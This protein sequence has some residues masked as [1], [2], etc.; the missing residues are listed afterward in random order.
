MFL[1]YEDAMMPLIPE[2]KF[3][4]MIQELKEDVMKR[5]KSDYVG[6][7]VNIFQGLYTYQQVGINISPYR[8]VEEAA[9]GE[10]M[11]Y[12]ELM[13][14]SHELA[15]QLVR[16][17][18]DPFK[19]PETELNASVVFVPRNNKYLVLPHVLNN[20]MEA[21]MQAILR[22]NGAKRYIP[23]DESYREYGP[24]DGAVEV[25][26]VDFEK[27]LANYVVPKEVMQVLCLTTATLA[28][29]AAEKKTEV[30]KFGEFIKM[31]N[32]AG[33]MNPD[34]AYEL[35]SDAMDFTKRFV[36]CHAEE[37]RSLSISYL[38]HLDVAK[39]FEE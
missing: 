16:R 4:A 18:T 1:V 3:Q 14:Q 24:E 11:G 7:V 26:L 17:P 37:I 34:K 2:Q 21:C 23:D 35:C 8:E 29:C 13:A 36:E 31:K 25:T 27:D 9:T 39:L 32:A 10:K 20:S 5:A 15:R 19:E 38:A 28:Y 33:E 6:L 22:E 12:T 30:E